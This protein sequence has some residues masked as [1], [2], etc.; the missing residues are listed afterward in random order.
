MRRG[1]CPY[2]CG[3]IENDSDIEEV[4]K[5]VVLRNMELSNPV[6]FLEAEKTSLE[7]EKASPDFDSGTP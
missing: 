4:V 1:I 7:M 2:L 5:R 3:M 6:S